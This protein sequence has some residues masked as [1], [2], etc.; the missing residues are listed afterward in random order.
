M[1]A[2]IITLRE[3]REVFMRA[4]T[5]G[6]V[7]RLWLAAAFGTL[8]VAVSLA[9]LAFVFADARFAGAAVIV[10]LMA[11]GVATEW[12]LP[13]RRRRLQM[14][15]AIQR[16]RP[17]AV[18]LALYVLQPQFED[19][20]VLA[21][22]EVIEVLADPFTLNAAERDFEFEARL[23]DARVRYERVDEY[24]VHLRRWHS[25]MDVS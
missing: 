13:L 2:P 15:P 3:Q 19:I 18:R 25:D 6:R 9:I 16:N 23:D 4:T 20:D 22:S 8:A 24:T 12:A 7:E 1:P 11:V 14:R 17:A 21:D 10:A 5:P